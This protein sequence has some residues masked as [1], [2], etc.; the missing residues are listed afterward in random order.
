MKIITPGVANDWWVG[1]KEGCPC[2]HAVIEFEKG[3]DVREYKGVAG[4]AVLFTCPACSNE[5]RMH[6]KDYKQGLWNGS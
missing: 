5:S 2:C 3:D 4:P 1:R 6:Y